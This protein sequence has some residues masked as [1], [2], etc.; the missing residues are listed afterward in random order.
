M[1]VP[2]HNLIGTA[3]SAKGET[4]FSSHN[5]LTQKSTP[6]SFVNATKQEA[7]A[8]TQKAHEA[9]EPFQ[10]TPLHRRAAFLR[11][12][13]AAILSLGDLLLE[14]YCEES[15]LPKGRAEGE[16]SRTMGQ[17]EGFAA[18]LDAGQY[19]E[20]VI[21]SA[22]PDNPATVDLR[23][24][25]HPLGPIV[26]FGASNFPLAYSTAGG[27]TASALATGCPVVV[28]SHPMHAATGA[29]VASAILKAALDTK[30]PEG[31][32][33]NLNGNSFELGQQLVMDPLIKGVGFTGSIQGGTALYRMAQT[34]SEPIPVFAEMGSVNP[35][36][37]LP[38]AIENPENRAHWAQSIASSIALGSGQFCTNPGLVF[39]LE[40]PHTPGFIEQLSAAFSKIQPSSML[41]PHIQTAYNKG[42][43]EVALKAKLVSSQPPS[44]QQPNGTLGKGAIYEVDAATFA[45]NPNLSHE[46]FGPMSLVVR[47]ES[48]E[49]LNSLIK[50]L[51][52]QLTGAI[53][54]E[55]VQMS[56]YETLVA[57]LQDRVGRLIFNGVPTGVAVCAAMQHGGPFPASTDARFTAVGPLSMRRWLRPISF[58]NW[59]DAL[60][61]QALQQANPLGLWRTVNGKISKD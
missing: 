61:P 19:L 46:V 35:V 57:A 29:L 49:T 40:S 60:L 16:R 25:N 44:S 47:V 23:K 7:L 8:A 59:P 18:A 6:W 5:P 32:F 33:S 55:S 10:A 39:C 53:I 52:G 36:V 58:Q 28:K 27:D 50:K 12:I 4:H 30:M 3:Y 21:D 38:E 41:G 26:V 31:V 34:R 22:D 45:Q 14:T 1:E 43:Q 20:P 37:V 11:A 51:E 24:I 15:G 9:F 48:L 54:G 13:A 42:V 56:G 17:L 2:T